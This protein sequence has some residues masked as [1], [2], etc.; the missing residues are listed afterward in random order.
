MLFRSVRTDQKI[1][2]GRHLIDVDTRITATRGPAAVVIRVD[3]SEVA[4][5]VVDRT[6]PGLFTASD[7]FD[8]GIDLGSTVSLDYFDR[9]PFP[10]NGTVQR[11][12]VSYGTGSGQTVLVWSRDPSGVLDLT[13]PPGSVLQ[14]APG[15]SGPW[16]V[17]PVAGE[18]KIIPDP[19]KGSE[20]FR[21][22][23]E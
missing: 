9:A 14:S 15:L 10:F 3:G 22:Q 17:L 23:P 7:T 2:P 6:N 4:K 8:V 18:A 21:L 19:A 1:A 12:M 5:T 13:V 16:S 11:I 20:Y